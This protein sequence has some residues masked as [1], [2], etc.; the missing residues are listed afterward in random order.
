MSIAWINT[1]AFMGVAL[2]A[3]PIAIHL[4]VRQQ[5]RMVEFPSLRFLSHTALAAFRRRAIQDALLLACRVAIISLAVLA[6]A[7]PIVQT[8]A[9]TAG[10]ANRVSR[11]IVP[12]DVTSQVADLTAGTFRSARFIRATIAENAM[13][14]AHG[15]AQPPINA[16]SPKDEAQSV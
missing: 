7:G 15:T 16:G 10:H 9:R 4:L 5:T 1:T 14:V 6:L 8:A 11:A 2:V 13:S 12:L 3:L